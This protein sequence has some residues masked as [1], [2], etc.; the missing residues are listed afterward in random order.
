MSP[1]RQI[2]IRQCFTKLTIQQCK[3]EFNKQNIKFL[4]QFTFKIQAFLSGVTQQE[5]CFLKH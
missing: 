3:G 5:S 2:G 1:P 4:Y